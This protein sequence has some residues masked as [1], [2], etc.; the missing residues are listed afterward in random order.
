MVCLFNRSDIM[1]LMCTLGNGT[2]SAFYDDKNVLYISLHRYDGGTFYPSGEAGSINSCGE[3][4]GL[5]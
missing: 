3:D 4:E 5:G 2:Q 1:L